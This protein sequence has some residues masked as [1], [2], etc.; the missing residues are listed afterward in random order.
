M[1]DS[2]RYFWTWVLALGLALAMVLGQAYKSSAEEK[3]ML[4]D[5][6]ETGKI[7]NRA[8]G[9]SNVYFHPPSR[10]MVTTGNDTINGKPTKVLT[11]KYDKKNAG[12]PDG[13]GGWCGYYT[14]LKCAYP[15][16]CLLQGT[17]PVEKDEIVYLNAS[18]YKSLTFWV[19]GDK[20]G[21]SFKVGLADAHWD[22][23]GDTVR[24]RR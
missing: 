11:I 10:V 5:D 4:I 9:K 15:G 14:I 3:R 18:N 2:G 12:G 7:I 23:I 8:E 19:K 21:E 24:A 16:V 13:Y 17:T 1:K 6:F 22:Q 20:G